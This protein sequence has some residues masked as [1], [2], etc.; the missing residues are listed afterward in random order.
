MNFLFPT[1]ASPRTGGAGFQLSLI[2]P[3]TRTGCTSLTATVCPKHGRCTCPQGEWPWSDA[4]PLHSPESQH[5]E[6]VI[7]D[8]ESVGA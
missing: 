5:A 7:V 2:E 8:G 4:C 3:V 1:T 6:L